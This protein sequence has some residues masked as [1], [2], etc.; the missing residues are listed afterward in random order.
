MPPLP[1]E[2]V[3]EDGSPSSAASFIETDGFSGKQDVGDSSPLGM[4]TGNQS[5][6]AHS[7]CS[8][9][10]Q[11]KMRSLQKA[12]RA[13]RAQRLMVS[14]PCFVLGS[15]AL[16]LPLA[17]C[18][19][20]KVAIWYLLII[21]EWGLIMYFLCL[22][23]QD[24][25]A[26]RMVGAITISAVPLLIWSLMGW[27]YIAVLQM[28]DGGG[29]TYREREVHCS[30]NIWLILLLTVYIIG[31]VWLFSGGARIVF[32]PKPRGLLDS[33]WHRLARFFQLYGSVDGI[34]VVV[35][36]LY[37]GLG[38]FDTTT[39]V[40]T[41]L[42]NLLLGWITARPGFRKRVQNFLSSFG[43]SVNTAAAIAMLIGNHNPK[44]TLKKAKQL[45]CYVP[46]DLVRQEHMAVNE[47]DAALRQLTQPAR[48]GEVHAFLTHSW[49][50]CPKEKWDG[51]A[52]WLDKFRKKHKK[53]AKLWI[54]KFCIDQDAI[55]DN[56]QCLPVF[57]SGC[58][59]LLMSPGSTY[60]QRL[61]CVMEIFIFLEMG[62]KPSQ[63][64][65][66]DVRLAERLSDEMNSFDV[67]NAECFVASDSQRLFEAVEA[68]FP[69]LDDFNEAV[70]KVLQQA[71]HVALSPEATPKMG[72]IS[73][74]PKAGNRTPKFFGG[75]SSPSSGRPPRQV[76]GDSSTTDCAG[77]PSEAQALEPGRRLDEP[78]VASEVAEQG[79]SNLQP[80]EALAEAPPESPP[81]DA[82]NE[83]MLVVVW[84]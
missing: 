54:D 53:R 8:D 39:G 40:I 74:T 46:G 63:L 15:L 4:P 23:P 1:L 21:M 64:V 33:C 9:A 29:C 61:W 3:M 58:Q 77:L 51:L 70:R 75:D 35:F 82:D 69:L 67:R 71:V 78:T 7:V 50:D 37:G 83:L 6:D 81:T 65:F 16:W 36:A 27:M 73:L 84:V 38:V 14:G 62:S 47:P 26:T 13:A 60:L 5:D 10:S 12:K 68:G 24:R 28:T 79:S 76:S 19:A 43:T 59:L 49:H 2:E 32:C 45:F 57:L 41:G 42:N 34:R 52:H 25:I 44:D 80:Q 17:Y 31:L 72:F 66:T 48:L 30:A 55:A 18:L 56:L 20:N 22:L 11:L